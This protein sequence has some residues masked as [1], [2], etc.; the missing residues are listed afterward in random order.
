MQIVWSS[1]EED[2]EEEGA[3]AL[4]DYDTALAKLKGVAPNGTAGHHA[5]DSTSVEEGK[6]AEK[7][8]KL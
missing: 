2:N 8:L 4:D 3:D 1:E 5:F 7:A 6:A